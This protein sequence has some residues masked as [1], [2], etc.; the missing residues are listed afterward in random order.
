MKLLID[1]GNSRMKWGEMHDGK[2]VGVNYCNSRDLSGLPTLIHKTEKPEA[3]YIASVASNEVTAKLKNQLSAHWGITAQELESRQSCCGVQNGYRQ[4]AQIGI[5][6]WAAMISA[7]HLFGGPLCVV[8]CGSAMTVDVLDSAGDHLGGLIVPGLQMQQRQL[9]QG[10]AGIRD[11]EGAIVDEPWGRDTTTCIHHG[12]IEAMS[13]LVER[14]AKRL[15]RQLSDKVA[16][17]ITGGDAATII[18]QL[19]L[20][21]QFEELLVLQGMAL[22][23]RELERG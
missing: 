12:A 8:D 6:R 2:L 10:T 20:D 18:P 17:V 4:P 15:S 16:I 7:F 3:I 5:D 22:V 1:I 21:A 23:V 9:M 11:S 19:T 13:G 14:C